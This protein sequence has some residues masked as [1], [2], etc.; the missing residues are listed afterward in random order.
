MKKILAAGGIVAVLLVVAVALLWSNINTIIERGI[1]TIGPKILQAEVTVNKVNIEVT[2][3]SGTINGLTIGNPKGFKTDY[4]FKLG[5]IAVALDPAS[6]TTDTVRI[7]SVVIQAPDIIYEGLTGKSNLEQLQAN[8]LAF[9]GGGA[10]KTGAT[11]SAGSGKKVRIDY[12]KIENG[13]IGVSAALLQGKKLTVPLPTIELRDIGKNKDTT[14]ADA[15]GQVLGAINK[16]ALPAIQKGISA[17]GEGLKDA[18]R[19]LQEGAEKGFE[20]IKGLLGK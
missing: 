6:L 15:L 17:I 19:T 20:G 7:K 14:M 18:G 10:Q 8:A 13:N 12:L 11:D 5:S 16:A 4:A 1:E 2:E 3:G 9:V